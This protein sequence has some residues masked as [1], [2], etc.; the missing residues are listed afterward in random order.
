VKVAYAPGSSR[1]KRK[2]QLKKGE[3]DERERRRDEA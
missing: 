1:M 3:W 2:E